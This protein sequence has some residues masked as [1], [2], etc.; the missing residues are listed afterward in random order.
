MASIECSVTPP[1]EATS[2]LHV[3]RHREIDDQE[4]P[5]GPC[6]HRVAH[7]TEAD[8]RG[9][10]RG[11]GHHEVGAR[12]RLGE[13]IEWLRRDAEL[14]RERLGARECSIHDRHAAGT[15][16]RQVLRGESAGLARADDHD[17]KRVE[18]AQT[19]PGQL[20]RRRRDRDH[21]GA[22]A[23]FGACALAGA[24]RRFEQPVER[25]ARGADFAGQRV[26]VFQ[27]TQNLGLSKHH[28]VEAACDAER[29]PDR[30]GI[31]E[32]VDRRSRGQ[33]IDACAVL[34][35]S[36]Q[37]HRRAVRIVGREVEL[38]P[39]ARREDHGFAN[40]VAAQ[41]VRQHAARRVRAE[42]EGFALGERRRP[43]IHTDDEEVHN[44]TPP[45]ETPGSAH[46]DLW[47]RAIQARLKRQAMVPTV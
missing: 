9:R 43:V 7:G 46:G 38:G 23:G 4:G 28:R 40:G 26:G 16:P 35:R 1:T 18:R 25:R 33:E 30:G 20:A 22:D 8:D 41:R 19:L 10:C 29:V 45:I 34:D 17:A 14:F 36:P 31:V 11:G 39:V 47:R 32:P 44:R 37:R 15:M 3:A 6:R 21:A 2:G 13:T 27:L 5:I 42:R 12:D 24:K